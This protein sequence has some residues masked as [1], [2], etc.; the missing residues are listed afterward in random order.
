VNVE[1]H[2][3]EF[4]PEKFHVLKNRRLLT[5]SRG[6]AALALGVDISLS[7]PESSPNY[8][9]IAKEPIQSSALSENHHRVLT[10]PS[11]QTGK[12]VFQPK[13]YREECPTTK[14]RMYIF[15]KECE[16]YASPHPDVPVGM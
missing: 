4:I 5:V 8:T 11:R 13:H 10:E 12:D 6:S 1:W 2:V 15:L 3:S 16:A 7:L 9:K 14:S